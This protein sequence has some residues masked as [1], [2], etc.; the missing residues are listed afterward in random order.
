MVNYP[1]SVLSNAIF[2]WLGVP[3]LYDVPLTWPERVIMF[4]ITWLLGIAWWF[5]LGATAAM[6]WQRIRRTMVPRDQTRHV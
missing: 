5:L 4:S 3:R 2:R 6:F 1:P